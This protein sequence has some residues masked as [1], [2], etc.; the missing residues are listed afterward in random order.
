[1][2]GPRGRKTEPGG[3]SYIYIYIR[4]LVKFWEK[5]KKKHSCKNFYK[6]VIQMLNQALKYYV[7][8]KISPYTGTP[9]FSTFVLSFN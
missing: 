2:S 8:G 5:K 9:A 7:S 3:I 6:A 1:M 4:C